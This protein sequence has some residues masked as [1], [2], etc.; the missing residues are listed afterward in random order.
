MYPP[1][2]PQTGHYAAFRRRWF[3]KIIDRYRNSPTK[4]V[5]FRLPRGPIL[6]PGNLVHKR[7]SSIRELSQRPN[8]LLVPEHTFD[9]LEHPELFKD[10][11]HLNREGIAR[12][13]PMLA[14]EVSKLLGPPAPRQ[15]GK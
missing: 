6:R 10:A 2:K 13:S 14:E 15:A 8:V 4:I 9:V 12:F 11:M 7:S 3:G 1:G 5:F